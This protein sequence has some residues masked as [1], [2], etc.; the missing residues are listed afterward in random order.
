[1]E[2]NQ[3][4][5]DKLENMGNYDLP[6][7]NLIVTSPPY[8]NARNYNNEPIFNNELVWAAWCASSIMLL[9]KQLKNNG[10]IWWNTGSGYKDFRRL[11]VVYSMILACQRRGIYLIDD[12]PWIKK[13]ATPQ[14][15]KK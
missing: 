1:M 6:K 5:N 3:I 14:K 15:Y 4:V 13:S 8:F 12:I 11:T 7:I 9:S 10:V 2:F